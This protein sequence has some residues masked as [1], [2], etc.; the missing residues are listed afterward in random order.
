MALVTASVSA[1]EGFGT[2]TTAPAAQARVDSAILYVVVGVTR[3][4]DPPSVDLTAQVEAPARKRLCVAHIQT[5]GVV[6]T[7]PEP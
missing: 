5:L 1:G 6:R 7:V 4:N 3:G 2:A